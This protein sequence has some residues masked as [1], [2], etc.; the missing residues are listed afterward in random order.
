MGEVGC[1]VLDLYCDSTREACPQ[2]GAAQFTGLDLKDATA[3]ALKAGWGTV[4]NLQWPVDIGSRPPW[5]CPS[6]APSRKGR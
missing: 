2:V 1:F 5:L 4:L 6:C 3:E